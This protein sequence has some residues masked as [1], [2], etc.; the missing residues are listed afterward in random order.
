MVIDMATSTLFVRQWRCKAYFMT[1]FT[2]NGKML[3]YK[4][5]SSFGVIEFADP[6]NRLERLFC[7]AL[8][9]ILAKLVLMD[10]LMAIDTTTKLQTSK[11][12]HILAILN[13]SFMAIFAQNSSMLSLKLEFCL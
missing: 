8:G 3:S 5:I 6:F 12:L 13:N 10:I 7:M 2:G 9:A 4:N 1:C 11:L